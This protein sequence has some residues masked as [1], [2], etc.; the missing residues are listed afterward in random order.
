MS[1]SSLTSSPPLVPHASETP[2]SN[3]GWLLIT[4][5]GGTLAIGQVTADDTEQ[6]KRH[7]QIR[8]V[9]SAHFAKER[10]LFGRNIKVLLL[11]FI[12]EVARSTAT[13]AGKT[14][15]VNTAR[16]SAGFRLT[17]CAHFRL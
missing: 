8:E 12:G 7:I 14:H 17:W 15:W 10:E 4:S 6:T 11:C 2:L 16:S 1:R 5:S 9:I 13:T 3:R